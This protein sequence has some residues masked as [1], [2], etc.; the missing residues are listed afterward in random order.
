MKECAVEAGGGQGEGCRRVGTTSC[1][2]RQGKDWIFQ[3]P[4]AA[5]T[6]SRLLEK[7]RARFL[8]PLWEGWLPL[9]LLKTDSQMKIIKNVRVVRVTLAAIANANISAA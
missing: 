3:P 6:L 9:D 2:R 7:S 4:T 5:S 1:S 8:R